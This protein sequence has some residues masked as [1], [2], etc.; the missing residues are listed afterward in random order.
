MKLYEITGAM[1]QLNAMM[2]DEEVDTQTIIDTLD[3]LNVLLE[4]KL[5]GIA[6][7]HKNI[8]AEAEMFATEAKRLAQRAKSL[9]N[10]A[11][12]LKAYAKTCLE[13]AGKD[14]VKAGLFNVRLQKNPASVEVVDESKIPAV[15]RIPQPDAI[16]KKGL[17]EDLKDGAVVEGVRLVDDKKHLR[18]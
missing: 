12:G 15:Y 11:E 18:F 17:L 3:S 8:T 13:Q 7:Y 14:K 2:E 1:A 6:K 10:R 9:E 5:E 16:D 4:D